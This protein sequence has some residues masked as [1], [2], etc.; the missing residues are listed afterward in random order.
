MSH[1]RMLVIRGMLF[2]YPS[3]HLSTCLST[4]LPPYLCVHVPFLLENICASYII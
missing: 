1:L 3:T 4:H 2:I